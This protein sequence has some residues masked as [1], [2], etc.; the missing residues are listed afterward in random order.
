[1]T[2]QD[3][4]ERQRLFCAV[5]IPASVKDALSEYSAR[6]RERFPHVKA[7]WER[8][9][10]MHVTV[11][12]VGEVESSRVLKLSG[13]AER[14]AGGFGPVTL[15]ME[16]TGVFPP[17]RRP[18][19][20]LWV[21]IADDAGRLAELQRRLE[22]EAH[23]AGF[24]REGRAFHP[25]LTLA[26]IR[27]PRGARELVEAHLAGEFA[28]REFSVE[29]LLVIRSELSPAGSKYTTLSRHRL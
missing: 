11:K 5:E 15:R 23:V 22:D 25:H 12:F 3:E 26:R 16:G 24:K 29:E 19:R 6:L 28:P 21:G 17:V 1:M 7:S 10:K 2:V 18:P 14:A 20:V 13:A 4:P 8:S 27:D 9:E